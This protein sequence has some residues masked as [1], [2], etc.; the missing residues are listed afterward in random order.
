MNPDSPVDTAEQTKIA[1]G[2]AVY[3][4]VSCDCWD[5]DEEVTIT[6]YDPTQTS[7]KKVASLT[8]S[9]ALLLIQMHI[10]RLKDNS[11]SVINAFSEI[12][13]SLSRYRKVSDKPFSQ[14]MRERLYKLLDH[15]KGT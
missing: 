6:T 8:R 4:T 2:K 12:Q 7:N 13:F 1:L 11:K 14:P 15:F 9:V 3:D 10:Q 5:E